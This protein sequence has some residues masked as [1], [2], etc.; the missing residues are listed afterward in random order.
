[1]SPDFRETQSEQAGQLHLA[2]VLWL[3]CGRGL[4][5]PCV[6]LVPFPER[7]GED[8]VIT[9]SHQCL[10][11]S[12]V[13]GGVPQRISTGRDEADA[14]RDAERSQMERDGT[15]SGRQEVPKEATSQAHFGEPL[16]MQREGVSRLHLSCS[17]LGHPDYLKQ[18]PPLG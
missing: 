3:V 12:C 14:V 16:K 13:C 18:A 7:K 17:R 8:T 1:M 11:V 5:P 6:L 9:Q 10:T 2:C 15:L 4:A